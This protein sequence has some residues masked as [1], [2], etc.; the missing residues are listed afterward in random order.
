MID[1]KVI[2]KTS[3]SLIMWKNFLYQIG[4]FFRRLSKLIWWLITFQI[5]KKIIDRWFSYTNDIENKGNEKCL[6]FP[7]EFFNGGLKSTSKIAVVC[8][9][10]YPD[11]LGEILDFLKNIPYQYD[12]F[13][14][15]NTAEKCELITRYLLSDQLEKFEVR[16]IENRGRDIA[17]KLV[18][19]SDIY[20]KYEFFLHLHT[21]KSPHARKLSGWRSYLLKT[22]LGS[23]EIVESVFDAF[24]ADPKLGI[25]AP[26]HF[27]PLG[28]AIGWGE[29]D[30]YIKVLLQRLKIDKKNLD[31]IDFPSGSMFWGRSAAL[32]PLININLTLDDFQ[33]E[34]GQL[35]GTMAHA[36]ERLFFY[37]C[38]KA[39]YHWIKMAVEPFNTEYSEGATPVKVNDD[40]LSKI[41][42]TQYH[43]LGVDFHTAREYESKM[44]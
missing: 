35:D 6:K 12:L 2:L 8:H 29:N 26:Q 13:I 20:I 25:V 1:K 16:V 42:L 23:R 41:L 43:L 15:T 7:F 30:N 28:R 36:I 19:C 10:Y 14:T 37:V 4:I 24:E 22:L 18:A 32:F 27:Y 5:H 11:L 21:K 40:I 34:H 17:P 39:G 44:H 3:E 9:V 33:N 31:K 38:E